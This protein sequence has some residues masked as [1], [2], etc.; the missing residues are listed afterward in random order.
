MQLKAGDPVFTMAQPDSKSG[1]FISRQILWWNTT[2]FEPKTKCSHMAMIAE[3]SAILDDTDDADFKFKLL[4]NTP[5]IEQTAGG[6]MKVKLSKYLESSNVFVYHNEMVD[7]S[8]SEA[9]TEAGLNDLGKTYG[10]GK[11]FLFWL[12]AAL[13]KLLSLP[14][15]LL[16][17][18]FGQRWRGIEI[19]F[20]SL[21]N[22]TGDYVCSQTI[23]KYYWIILGICFG[24]HW[25][26]VT[27]DR[28]MDW[29]ESNGQWRQVFSNE[30]TIRDPEK[31]RYPKSNVMKYA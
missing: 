26:G 29:C 28:A 23:A 20:F 14:V 16:G 12:D 6:Q 10:Y 2:W 15:C 27:P 25:R 3:D 8:D 30:V 11:I 21:L 31:S 1:G 19:P 18:I 4:G 24:E 13:G 5:V 22:I 7:D 9:L 17:W